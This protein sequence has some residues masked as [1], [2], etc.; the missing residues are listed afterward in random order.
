MKNLFLV[1]GAS[2]TGKSDFLRWIAD[3]NPGDISIVR[4]ATTRLQRDY[5]K[6]D[7]EILLDLDFLSSEDFA[8][9][10]FDYTYSYGGFQ[11]GFRASD[12]TR[13]L[14]R[15]ENVFLIIRNIAVIQ[16]IVHNFKLINVVP[17]YT[18]TDGT[19]LEKRLR[20]AGASRETIDFRLKR[21]V[22]ALRDYY[23]HP[24]VY[25][26]VIINNSSREVFHNTI[27][28]LIAKYRAYPSIDPFLVSVMMSYNP[29]NKKLDDY[30][31]A[32]EAAVRSTAPQFACRRV[33][34]APGSPKIAEEFRQL[35]TRSRCVIV[36]LTENKQSVYYELGYIHASGKACII[37]AE[38]GTTPSFYPREHKI[39]FYRSARE[40]RDQLV[41]ALTGLL[42][43]WP[44]AEATPRT[45]A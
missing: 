4:K 17:V 33:D 19:E 35:I 5:E 8:S 22:L 36:D 14:L 44:S 18:Y 23:S 16:R 40:L 28:R 38:E 1:D 20:D 10:N 21:S 12:L 26:E 29:D 32:M 43:G 30:Y 6:A 13:E 27:D 39:L 3:N 31:D 2:G 41:R 7:P 15:N 9:K 34:K 37:T 45:S 42:Q 24:D 25:K 11:Y